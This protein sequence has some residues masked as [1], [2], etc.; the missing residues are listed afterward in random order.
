MINWVDK[1][2]WIFFKHQLFRGHR[3]F[4]PDL[5]KDRCIICPGGS[6]LKGSV[7]IFGNCS[8]WMIKEVSNWCWFCPTSS[9]V[10]SPHLSSSQAQK[11]LGMIHKLCDNP[12]GSERCMRFCHSIKRKI[13]Q[14][15]DHPK[16]K[17]IGVQMTSRS[18][19]MAGK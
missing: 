14:T 19:N 6:E 1:A 11:V 5:S 10:P 17:G 4:I 18:R 3:S 12:L 2:I 13:F 9:L 7:Q 15:K 16:R 8:Q